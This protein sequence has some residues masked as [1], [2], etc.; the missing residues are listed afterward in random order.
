MAWTEEQQLAR[1]TEKVAELIGR[2]VDRSNA[3]PRPLGYRARI[4]MKTNEEGRLGYFQPRSHRWVGIPICVIARPELNDVLSRL[5]P[6]P[7]IPVVELRSD[8]QRVVLAAS[9]Q[10]RRSRRASPSAR[11]QAQSR[12]AELELEALGLSGITLDARTVQGDTRLDLE[13]C[14]IRHRLSA[15]SFFQ[16]NLEI[17]ELLVETVVELV[18][19]SDP[20][21]IIDL[22]SGAGNLSLPLSARGFPTALVEQAPSSVADATASIRRHGLSATVRRG[23][24]GKLRGGDIF[25]DVAL[26]DPPRAGAPGLIPEL[27]LT[28]PRLLVYVSCN[29]QTLARDIA[30]A[31]DAGYEIER[32]E[33]FDM[34]PHTEHIETLC[35]LRRN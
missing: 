7:G 14:G 24:A 34:F 23:D 26:L 25:F 1:K 8:G 17:N 31:R 29:P 30:P 33:V 20:A 16:V 11:R 35:V 2:S 32:L 6:L 28:R 27:L 21:A 15:G 5:P 10:M 19:A 4:S 3:S 18:A 22:Y 13:V 12:L 9:M